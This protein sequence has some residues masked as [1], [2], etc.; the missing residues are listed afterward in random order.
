M[1]GRLQ[2]LDRPRRL[3][4]G[5]RVAIVAPS[6]PVTPTRLDLGVDVLRGWGLDPV[7]MPHTRGGH[8]RFDYLAADDAARAADLQDAWCDPQYAAVLCARGGYGAQRMVDLLDWEP[9]RAAR[10]KAFVGFSDVTVLQEA[11][12][13]RL[14]LATYYGPVAAGVV[15]TKDGPTQ[16]HLRRTLFE[17][18]TVTVLTSSTARALVPG[19]ADGVTFGGCASLL[20]GECGTRHARERAD[21]GILVLEDVGEAP[22]RLDRILTQLLRSGMLDGVA[23]VVLGS[24]RDCGPYEQVREVLL[25]RLG[26]LGVPVLEELGFGHGDGSLTVPLGLPAV[27]DADAATLTLRIPALA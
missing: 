24:W 9:M 21:G 8:D 6:G 23:G 4:P 12:A 22:Y 26:G 20:A 7:V 25:D 1:T 19:R 5:D 17:P 10:A 16:E 3:T 11:F 15:F 18:E 14:G 13:R 2:P 27:L